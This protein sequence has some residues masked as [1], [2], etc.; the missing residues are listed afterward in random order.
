MKQPQIIKYRSNKRQTEMMIPFCQG[1]AGSAGYRQVPVTRNVESKSIEKR[2]ILET[3]K[4]T[5]HL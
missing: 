1:S 2:H 5:K 4:T 3:G